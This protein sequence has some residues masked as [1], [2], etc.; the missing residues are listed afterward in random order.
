MAIYLREGSER[1]GEDELESLVKT[2]DMNPLAI[3]LTIDGFI[4]GIKSLNEMQT[5]AKQQV[6]DFSYRNLIDALPST[7]HELLEC[8][9]VESSQLAVQRLVIS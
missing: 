7:V 9:F 8:L 5:L 4:A 3:R 1:I 2:C 6:I